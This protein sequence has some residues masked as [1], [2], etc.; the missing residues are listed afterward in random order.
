MECW[1]ELKEGVLFTVGVAERA[2]QADGLPLW[3]V[4]T[5]KA[6]NACD[7]QFSQV[8]WLCRLLSWCG[9][10]NI[11]ANGGLSQIPLHHHM[12]HSDHCHG[13]VEIVGLR[14]LPCGMT[15]C[16]TCWRGWGWKL[17]KDLKVDEIM[18]YNVR[19]GS[20]STHFPIFS[21]SAPSAVSAITKWTS[22]WTG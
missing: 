9:T 2:S 13:I 16:W 17:M 15:S 22:C 14:H 4:N 19:K 1:R 10:V 5:V 18:N 7:Q 8:R 20:G 11:P 21:T 12:T 6:I 3:G